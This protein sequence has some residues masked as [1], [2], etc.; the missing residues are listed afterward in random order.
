RAS[1]DG[2]AHSRPAFPT[3]RAGSSHCG[4]ARIFLPERLR[5]R[6]NQDEPCWRCRRR[7]RNRSRS[8]PARR[9]RGTGSWISAS[10]KKTT[11]TKGAGREI[12]GSVRR[13]LLLAI[14]EGS[15]QDVAERSARVG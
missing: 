5:L 10:F 7:R 9:R 12:S 1:R 4:R 8:W 13:L 11:R 3:L 2:S 15:A 14:L 6:R